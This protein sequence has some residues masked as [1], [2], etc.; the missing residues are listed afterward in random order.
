MGTSPCS[1]GP[2]GLLLLQLLQAPNTPHNATH[3][4]GLLSSK[5]LQILTPDKK[6]LR[7]L[8]CVGTIS[9]F[10]R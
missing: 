8:S 5:V 2:P 4:Q 6:K 1:L 9:I 3:S 7:S 10:N